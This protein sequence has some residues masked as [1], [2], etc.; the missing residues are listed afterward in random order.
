MFAT[1]RAVVQHVRACQIYT[2]S[3]T[4][5]VQALTLSSEDAIHVQMGSTKRRVL[6]VLAS[7]CAEHNFN[8]YT[9]KQTHLLGTV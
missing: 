4:V 1:L 7:L 9:H 2:S 6:S 3:G 5:H 8:R